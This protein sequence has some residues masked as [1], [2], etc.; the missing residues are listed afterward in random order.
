[1]PPALHAVSVAN[2][3]MAL[4]TLALAA[5]FYVLTVGLIVGGMV[6]VA[7]S[8]TLTDGARSL[9]FA[10]SGLAFIVIVVCPVVNVFVPIGL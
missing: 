2:E 10:T 6:K 1:M 3:E 9:L 5:A 4:I 7:R 8:Q